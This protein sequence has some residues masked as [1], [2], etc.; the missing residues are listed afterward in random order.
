MSKNY[1]DHE[2]QVKYVENLLSKNTEWDWLIDYI[3]ENFDVDLE[4]SRFED[5]NGKFVEIR[6][7][8]EHL[9]RI[10]EL[11]D[12]LNINKKWLKDINQISQFYLSKISLEE[13]ILDNDFLR[14]L[15]LFVLSAKIINQSSEAKYYIHKEIFDSYNIFEIIDITDF[16]SESE[17]IISIIEQIELDFAKQRTIF[18]DNINC[19]YHSCEKVSDVLLDLCHNPNAFSFNNSFNR[20]EVSTW[21]ETYLLELL[22]ANY[23]NGKLKPFIEYT[24]GSTYPNFDI[25]TSDL[26]SKIN[27]YYK[28]TEVEFLLESIDYALNGNTPSSETIHHHFYLLSLNIDNYNNESDY[29]SLMCSS[30]EFVLAFWEDKNVDTKNEIEFFQKTI[31]KINNIEYLSYLQIRKAPLTKD[32]IKILNEYRERKA[33]EIDKIKDFNEFDTYINDS[34]ITHII[35]KDIFYKISDKFEEVLENIDSNNNICITSIF[36]DYLLLL[37]KIQNN[38]GI[39]SKEVSA[40]II[41]IRGLWQDQYFEICNKSLHSFGDTIEIKNKDIE[42]YN[43]SII[44][45]PLAFACTCLLLRKEA[46]IKSMETLSQYPMTILMNNIIINEYFPMQASIFIDNKHPID[47]IYKNQIEKVY[48]GNKY[49]FV[50]SL[51]I[52]QY[53]TGLYRDIKQH[54]EFYFSLFMDTE[55]L[56]ERVREDNSKYRFIEYS[57]KPT[58]AHL[59]QLFPIIESKIRELGEIFGISPICEKIDKY[60]KLKEPSTVLRKIIDFLYNETEDLLYAGDFF[61]IHFTLFA[62]NGLNIRNEC[63]HGNGYNT[64]NENILYAFKI[65]LFCLHLLEYRTKLIQNNVLQC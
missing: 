63:I 20:D 22:S 58:L 52:N 21:E 2:I 19:V 64:S 36:L 53:V 15:T 39:I 56:Y 33:K 8:F 50:N 32:I 25:Y 42:N 13:L 14:M 5:F 38:K 41:F 59:T 65:T 61:F 9:N 51:T 35:D 6:T 16:I 57:D 37:I 7:V 62:E 26:L 31:S 54:I 60:Y 17:N 44:N 18:E 27:N 1:F 29:Y 49:R 46:L 34:E 30:L 24:D 40:E 45:K 28:N 48:N 23:K 12:N 4:I 10:N 47:M 43:A 11:V 55:K 3:E